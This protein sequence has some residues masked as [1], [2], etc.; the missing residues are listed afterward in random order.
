MNRIAELTRHV[1]KTCA[2]RRA[3]GEP[4]GI[5]HELFLRAD[6][7]CCRAVAALYQHL[8]VDIYSVGKRKILF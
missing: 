2:E 4:Y 8:L 6:K 7:A 5:T 3:L 1:G